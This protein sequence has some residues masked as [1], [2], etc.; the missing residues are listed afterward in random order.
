M[1]S[2]AGAKSYMIFDDKAVSKVRGELLENDA[3]AVVSSL[4]SMGLS[5]EEALSLI[6]KYWE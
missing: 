1:E 6:E 3:T 5:K 2:R 4:K